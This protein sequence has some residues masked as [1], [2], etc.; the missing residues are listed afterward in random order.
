MVGPS[1]P[2]PQAEEKFYDGIDNWPRAF[3]EG[4]LGG[5]HVGKVVVRV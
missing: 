5:D 4:V 3:I 1:L 2:S